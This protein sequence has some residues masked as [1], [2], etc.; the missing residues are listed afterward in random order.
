MSKNKRGAAD[1]A[2]FPFHTLLNSTLSSGVFQFG[3]SPTGLSPRGLIEA[4]TWT[5]Y[6]ITRLKFRLLPPIAAT[7][8][9]VGAAWVSGIQDTPPATIADLG[10][11]LPFEVMP[12]RQTVPSSWVNVSR[13]E[14]AGCFPWYKTIPGG[15]D[16]T[17]EQPGALRVVGTS[18]EPFIIEFRGVF[19]FKGAIASGNTPAAQ[20]LQN[21]MRALRVTHARELEKARLLAVIAAPGAIPTGL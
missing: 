3:G 5:H 13:G 12:P 4:D 1:S 20:R 19:E 18:A 21:E 6:R 10:E 2:P 7:T 17:E 15:A 14:L 11:L 9:S 8:A 16:P